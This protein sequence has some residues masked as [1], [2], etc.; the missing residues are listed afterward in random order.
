MPSQIG[1]RGLMQRLGEVLG[2]ED[3]KQAP[4]DMKV[5]ELIPVIAVDPGMAGA[6]QIQLTGQAAIGGTSAWNWQ[7]VGSDGGFTTP[8]AL[9]AAGVSWRDNGKKEAVILGLRIEVQ[10]PGGIPIPA[11]VGSVMRLYEYR[12]AAGNP[13]SVVNLSTFDG[14]HMVDHLRWQYFFSYPMWLRSDWVGSDPENPVLPP[15]IMAANPIYVPAGSRWGLEM[16]YWN[17]ALSALRAFPAG[18]ILNV[19]SFLSTCPAGMRPAGM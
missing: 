4:A 13:I 14:A 2:I 8:A 12:Q 7:M 1:N 5:D 18:T 9:N 3:V 15:S 11:E 19:A 17:S 6:G 16:Q 10:F